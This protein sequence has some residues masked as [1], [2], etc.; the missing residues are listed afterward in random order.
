M[1]FRYFLFFVCFISIPFCT[2]YSQDYQFDFESWQRTNLYQEPAS[3]STYNFISFFITQ[4][5]NV[6]KVLGTNG[7]AIRL[8]NKVSIYDQT[9]APG[10][11]CYGKL[12]S[13]PFGGLAIGQIPDSFHM[14]LRFE[15]VPTDT[16]FL[17]LIFKKSG[18][19]VSVNI[20]PITG[21][22]LNFTDFKL[23]LIS[24]STQPDTVFFIVSS[25]SFS[26][27][28]KGS[29]LEL[30]EFIFLN[31][32]TQIPNNSFENWED[33]SIEEPLEWATPNLTPTFFRS[34]IPVLK[35]LDSYQGNYALQIN[36]VHTVDFG[37][38]SYL[39]SAGPGEAG[40]GAVIPLPL[41]AKQLSL[42]FDYKYQP[43]GID[44]A[45]A[46]ASFF[47]FN[48]QT[49]SREYLQTEIIELKKV[50]TYIS[51]KTNFNFI[52]TCDSVYLEFFSSKALA[53]NFKN[54]IP[55][56][57]ST[58]W[59][60]DLKLKKINT[61]ASE[62][63]DSD[64]FI[65]TNPVKEKIILNRKL[66]KSSVGELYIVN[67]DGVI[68]GISNIDLDSNELDV[69]FLHRG[70]YYLVSQGA[71]IKLNVAFIKI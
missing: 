35:S 54:S 32:S 6:T 4:T 10:I 51:Y 18:N 59:I 67:Q 42:E 1:S 15:I 58:L 16:A 44:T 45:I 8:E 39:G 27:P 60:D 52:E 23:P 30:D 20:F 57:G 5:P 55:K 22:L 70:M 43:A 26:N 25:G 37:F 21:S 71:R 7:S 61:S 13:I 69:S 64:Y 50:Q 40:T 66:Q 17:A 41:E 56:V 14:R 68:V 36:T 33:I 65:V 3:F 63:L 19:A 28:K 38:D 34:D 12:S 46:I 31:S 47:K 29:Y 11:I 53:P 24:S 2:I 9:V 48:K 49:H 62:E